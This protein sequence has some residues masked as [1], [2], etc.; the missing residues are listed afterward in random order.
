MRPPPSF[1]DVGSVV[2]CALRSVDGHRVPVG[3]SVVGQFVAGESVTASVGQLDAERL[4]IEIDADNRGSGRRDDRPVVGW[5]ERHDSIAA[6]LAAAAGCVE[7]G[8]G[9][10]ASALPVR[11]TEGVERVDVRPAPG[12][13][14]RVVPG[15]YVLRP[16]L[17]TRTE[18]DTATGFDLDRS[19]RQVPL[20]RLATI[21]VTKVGERVDLARITLADVLVEDVDDLAVGD[22]F[23]SAIGADSAELAVVADQDDLGPGHVGG[24]DES[25]EVVV[26][27]HPGFVED[28]HRRLVELRA[29]VVQSPKQRR[30]GR[31][32]HLRFC[33][34]VCEAW[35]EVAVP[36]TRYPAD[37]SAIDASSSTMSK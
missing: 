14:R 1:E 24:G 4:P 34:G 21:A 11:S 9:E 22:P 15:V 36:T 32:G 17:S 8:T 10:P 30:D 25:Q 35:P 12:Q 19:L 26:V 6:S 33:A 27:N 31:A 18:R 13:H 2:G 29:A 7:L 16:A 37:A 23:E 3:E 5:S 20:D 28:H